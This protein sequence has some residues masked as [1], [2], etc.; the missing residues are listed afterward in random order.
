MSQ[1]VAGVDVGSSYTKAVL[2]GPDGDVLGSGLT[3]SGAD[4]AQAA[5]TALEE[6]LA[7]AGVGREGLA[8]VVATGYGRTNVAFATGHRT[9]IDC[10]ARGAYHHVRH[11]ATIV[12]V[13]GQDNKVI[14]VDD[15][16]RRVDFTMNRKCA[17]GTGSFLEEMALW[18]R[19]PL[20]ELPRLAERATDP[21]VRI[22]SYCTVFARTEL[23][24]RVREGVTPA[25]LA[26]AAYESVARRVLETRALTDEIVLTGGVIA[27]NPPFSKILSEVLER[28]VVVPPD[29][30]HCGALGAALVALE[31]LTP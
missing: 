9:E 31:S 26:R 18:L 21:S 10:H 1:R 2:L 22:G 16:G 6:A 19:I 20:D 7:Q 5:E 24:A 4:F 11:A 17:A 23:L 30:Q 29:P 13:G 15:A 25:N 8:A 27:H 14:R 28:P 12:D 3:P